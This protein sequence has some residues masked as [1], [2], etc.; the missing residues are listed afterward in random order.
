MLLSFSYQVERSKENI[1]LANRIPPSGVVMINGIPH[2]EVYKPP[3]PPDN[4]YWNKN[5]ILNMFMW[6]VIFVYKQECWKF[7]FAIIKYYL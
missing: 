4:K 2:V 3:V 6:D 7:I 1:D 5:F